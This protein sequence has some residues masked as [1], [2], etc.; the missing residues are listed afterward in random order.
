MA[1]IFVVGMAVMDFVFTVDQ[2]PDKADKYAARSATIVGGGPAANAAVAIVRLGG[3]AYLGGRL[4]DD[5][6]GDLI[7][8]DLQHEQ[9]DISYVQRCPGAQSSYS[10]VYLN[11]AGERQIV[12]FRGS[13]LCTNTDWIDLAPQVDAVL[14]DSRWVEASARALKWAQER[15]IPGVLDAEAPVDKRLLT[16]ASHIACSKQ[17]LMSLAKANS[18]EDALLEVAATVSGFC[19][20]TDGANG[21]F[22]V[23]NNK[24]ETVPAYPVNVVDTLGAGDIW[25]GA[26]T[27]RLAEG[28]GEKDAV[29]FANAAAA[30]KCTRSGGRQGCP[31]RVATEHFIKEK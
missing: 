25:H 1:S 8:T 17:G 23:A 28:A 18:L 30:I 2:M 11:S 16:L 31:D 4:G 10:S 20:V 14:V 12:N 6:M 27:L 24:I 13:G 29:I 7:V 3:K 5:Y 9:V 19:S 26:F 21:T 22:Y 15:G